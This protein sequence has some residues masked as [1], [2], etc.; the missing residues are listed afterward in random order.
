MNPNAI[1]ANPA[2]TTNLF[3][4]RTA[5]GGPIVEA[6]PKLNATGN[7]RT[8]VDNGLKPCRN[9]KYM[10]DQEDEAEQ[11][12]ERDCDGATRGGEPQVCEQPD[13]EHRLRD[14]PL[15]EHEHDEGDR[16]DG[17]AGE[18]A[19]RGPSPHGRLD[20]RVDEQADRDRRQGQTDPIE[21]RRGRVARCRNPDRDRASI[22][23]AA[24]GTMARKMLPHQ[25]CSSSQPP[26]IGP[27]ATAIPVV[28]P[29]TPIALARSVLS[30]NVFERIDKVF[31]N[32]IAAPTPIIARA[33]MS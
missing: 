2:P 21:T 28:A 14:A 16:R 6:A 27:N 9:W 12:E 32:T 5:S 1:R 7:K 26:T 25:K 10:R 20:D 18:R 24:A 4:K 29:H 22:A 17:E 8:P 19:G 33:A 13:V 30:V 15:P 3:P 11:R 31:G 23:T